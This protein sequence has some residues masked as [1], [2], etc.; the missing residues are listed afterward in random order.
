MAKKK[1]VAPPRARNPHAVAALK[2]NAGHHGPNKRSE[3]RKDK[4]RLRKETLSRSWEA[5]AA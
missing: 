1:T 3:R 5:S 2:L 4:A